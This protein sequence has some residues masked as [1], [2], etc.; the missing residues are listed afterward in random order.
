M[1]DQ[2]LAVRRNPQATFHDVAELLPAAMK[3]LSSIYG[4]AVQRW[5]RSAWGPL[6]GLIDGVRKHPEFHA[7][8]RFRSMIGKAICV[9]FVLHVM[10]V[11]KRPGYNDF[12]IS[13]WALLGDE[14]TALEM[15]ER[16]KRE[17]EIGCTICWALRS[18]SSQ[19]PEFRERFEG[20]IPKANPEHMLKN[21]PRSAAGGPEGQFIDSVHQ[22]GD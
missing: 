7:W 11:K 9:W 18:L 4:T 19:Y 14:P 12:L 10:G 22:G 1:M 5:P 8:A 3:V 13:R 6:A 21:A 15:I 2:V 17:D 20:E 16:S